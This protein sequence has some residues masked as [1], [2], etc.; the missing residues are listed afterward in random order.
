LLSSKRVIKSL[1][2]LIDGFEAIESQ[3]QEWR[4]LEEARSIEKLDLVAAAVAP[5]EMG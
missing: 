4:P 2:R 5:L 1:Q 3:W